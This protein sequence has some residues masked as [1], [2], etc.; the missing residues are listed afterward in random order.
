[1]RSYALQ[2]NFNRYLPLTDKN[3]WPRLN[4]LLYSH[5]DVPMNI[6]A[7]QSSCPLCGAEHLEITPVL[8]HMICAYIGPQY[9]FAAVPNGYAC[10]KC[11]RSIVSDDMACEI[12]G[13]SARCTACGKEMI[14]SP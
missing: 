3:L 9:D 5:R 13:V 1:M 4:Y 11:R 7:G 6:A 8:H 12:V 2:Q 14:V 10:P